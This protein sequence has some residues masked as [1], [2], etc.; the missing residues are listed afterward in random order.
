LPGLWLDRAT[1]P[2]VRRP[3]TELGWILTENLVMQG[4]VFGPGLASWKAS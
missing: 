2:G 3:V 1:A 4:L